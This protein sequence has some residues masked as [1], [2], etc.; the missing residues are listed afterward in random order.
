VSEY[1]V[2]PARPE[3][4]SASTPVLPWKPPLLRGVVAAVFGMVTVFWQQPGGFAAALA[5]ALYLLA[6]AATV[7]WLRTL[8]PQARA[9]LRR[10]LGLEIAFLALAGL[11]SVLLYSLLP[12]AVTVAAGL[13]LAGASA[14]LAGWRDRKSSQLAKDMLSTSTVT[15]A[16]GIVLPLFLA[17]GPKALLGV[18]G[19][20]AI[21]LAVLLLL[22]GLSYRH[23]ARQAGRR[24]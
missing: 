13:I 4:A 19:G 1:A 17:L 2:P 23:D 21:I 8:L 15:L 10:A 11:A 20:S 3:T 16:T 6:T 24:P 5:T 7:L 18:L 12:Y 9:G 14:L 22:A